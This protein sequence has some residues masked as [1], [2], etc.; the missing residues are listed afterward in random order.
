MPDLRVADTNTLVLESGRRIEAL[1][2]AIASLEIDGEGRP[3]MLGERMKLLRGRLDA[4][5]WRAYR[6]WS[7]ARNAYVHAEEDAVPDVGGFHRD[8]LRVAEAL[9]ALVAEAEADMGTRDTRKP[10]APR[11]PQSG[12]A[13]ARVKD[14]TKRAGGEAGTHENATAD[15]VAGPLLLSGLIVGSLLAYYA[16]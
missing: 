5:T 9:R 10:R 16:C 1:A 8:Y 2:K 3:L 15:G 4:G 13:A 7:R 12:G 11:K 14:E 6:S